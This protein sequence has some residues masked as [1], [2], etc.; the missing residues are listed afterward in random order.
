MKRA[1]AIIGISVTLSAACVTVVK[2]SPKTIAAW[3]EWGMQHPQWHPAPKLPIVCDRPPL[4]IEPAETT[5]MLE[6]PIE[7]F[8]AAVNSNLEESPVD[9]YIAGGQ[10]MPAESGGAQL[11]YA[12]LT[13][14]GGL[15]PAGA[16]EPA[17]FLLTGVGL[18]G[19]CRKVFR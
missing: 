13:I 18:L 11:V 7:T 17:T 16:P 19:L 15:A 1:I 6:E 10:E 12:N 14:P 9:S 8:D 4:T 3:R 2:H 5:E